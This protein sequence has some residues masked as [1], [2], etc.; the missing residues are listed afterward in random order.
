VLQE[1]SL[2]T[3]AAFEVGERGAKQ[4]PPL[5]PLLEEDEEGS[6]AP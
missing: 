6:L 3:L 2:P 4:P 1:L 5:L